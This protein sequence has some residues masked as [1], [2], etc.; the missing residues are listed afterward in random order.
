MDF[1]PTVIHAWAQ[2]DEAEELI[3]Y[4]LGEV[5]QPTINIMQSL[6]GEE[7][8]VALVYRGQS[9]VIWPWKNQ[10]HLKYRVPADVTEERLRVEFHA[11]GGNPYFSVEARYEHPRKTLSQLR[12]VSKAT[13]N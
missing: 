8:Q 2:R 1:D 5:A 6:L 12:A 7:L 4:L 3:R 10:L 9:S 13:S 11:G